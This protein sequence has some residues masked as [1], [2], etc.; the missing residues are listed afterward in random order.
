MKHLQE[1]FSLTDSSLIAMWIKNS[2][3][4]EKAGKHAG[5]VEF[6]SAAH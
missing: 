4:G 5:S 6:E 1:V 2:S 3:I